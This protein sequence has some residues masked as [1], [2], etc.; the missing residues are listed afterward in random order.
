MLFTYTPTRQAVLDTAQDLFS[1]V[2]SGAVKIQPPRV[3]PLADAAE[4]HRALEGRQTVG[5][6]VLEART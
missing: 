4:A 6:T 1:V 5:S 3:F 2:G